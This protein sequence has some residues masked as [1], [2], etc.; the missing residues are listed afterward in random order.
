MCFFKNPLLIFPTI[1]ATV[2]CLKIVNTW[3]PGLHHLDTPENAY[4]HAL[5]NAL[6]VNEAMKWN[7]NLQKSLVWA[8]KITDWHE[9]F[10]P[11]EPLAKAMDLHNNKVGRS[12]FVE[13]GKSK[14]ACKTA[15]IVNEIRKF[16]D[17]AQK[18]T[19]PLEVKKYPN[20]L[21]YI[22]K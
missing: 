5:W 1:K 11:N 10:A 15:E 16:I 8:K 18:I 12:I 2:M 3:F 17:S 22:K 9:E 7:K 14:K 4:R 6:I 21:V 20:Q 19:D 13:F